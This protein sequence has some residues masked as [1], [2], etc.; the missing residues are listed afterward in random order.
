LPERMVFETVTPPLIAPPSAGQGRYAIAGFSVELF[1]VT[2]TRGDVHPPAS[3]GGGV[4]REIV[5]LVS[6]AVCVEERD[7]AAARKMSALPVFDR[8]IPDFEDRAV[9]QC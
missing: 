9:T 3:I 4:F 8:L 1:S 7:A 5:T 6:V 2:P